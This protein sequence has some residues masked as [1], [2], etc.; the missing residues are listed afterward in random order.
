MHRSVSAWA[1]SDFFQCNVWCPSPLYSERAS[2][3]LAADADVA[4]ELIVDKANEK[5][6]TLS[7]RPPHSTTIHFAALLYI[8]RHFPVMWISS[9]NSQIEY[10][11]FNI[12]LFM[13]FLSTFYISS[14]NHFYC[15]EGINS[16]EH[17][18]HECKIIKIN[19]GRCGIPAILYIHKSP[20]QRPW[21]VL[22]EKQPIPSNWSCV[23]G[24]I[25][26]IF[27]FWIYPLIANFFIQP[28]RISKNLLLKQHIL[29]D[30]L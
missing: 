12:I 25:I 5:N 23:L 22:M 21:L 11:I 18:T 8:A 17:R 16:F 6:D 28:S 27:C 7:I 30:W 10:L 2:A 3:T 24:N 26:Y 4:R 14:F 19:S 9:F 29:I 1:P 13:M 15:F 20:S